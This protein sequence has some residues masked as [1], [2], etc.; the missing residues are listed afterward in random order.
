MLI[1]LVT[2]IPI[3]PWSVDPPHLP[4]KGRVFALSPLLDGQRLKIV[5]QGAHS[6]VHLFDEK[7]F[8]VLQHEL[9][10]Q[11]SV[12]G[13]CNFY[14]LIIILPDFKTQYKSD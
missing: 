1:Q 11:L 12:L 5:P 4:G 14:C 3:I 8:H 9:W 6:N 13:K 2:N 7:P 10:H